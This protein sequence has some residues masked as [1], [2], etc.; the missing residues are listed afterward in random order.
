VN[1]PI[2][3]EL[4]A[5]HQVT[6]WRPLVQW[7]LAIPHLM[8]AG[9]LRYFRQVLTLISFA[10]V[11]FKEEIPRPLFDALAMTYRYEWRAMSYV[12]FMHEDYPPFDFKLSS[13]DDGTE[14][15]TSLRF[16][17]PEHLERWKPL[18]KWFLAIP[19]YFVVAVLSIAACFGIIAGFFA[20]VVTGEYPD[21]IRNFLVCSY[22]YTL[23]VEA[24]VGLLTDHYP[25][26]SL[27]S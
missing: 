27:T 11:L 5:D 19:Q 1:S 26:F 8:I 13:D 3:I 23:R 25:P 14:T 24:Y 21:R 20:V 9:A 12:L 10:T 15:H 6:R 22:R 17:Y 2:Q 16:T 7:L 18:Y 4:H